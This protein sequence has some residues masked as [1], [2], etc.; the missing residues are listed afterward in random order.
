M[1]KALLFWAFLL[2]ASSPSQAAAPY[3]PG[4][5]VVRLRQAPAAM[6]IPLSASQFG[7]LGAPLETM[8]GRHSVLSLKGLSSRL[9]Q[10]RLLE[11]SSA[12]DIPALAGRLGREALV[13]LAE[14]D[15]YAQPL[16]APN[17]PLFAQQWHH[18]NTGQTG[19]TAGADVGSTAAW[20]VWTGSA[21]VV[22]AVLDTGIELSHPDLSANIASGGW[23]FIDNDAT[24]EDANGHGTH[25]SGII[26]AQGNNFSAVSG[27]LWRAK[28]L[29]LK[30]CGSGGC[31]FTAIADALHFAANNG[32]RVINMSLG[33]PSGSSLLEEAVNDA[34]A[35]G[36]VVVAAA[37]N[38]GTESPSY[39]A[40]Y[41]NVIAV[42]A[43]DHRD[44]LASFSQRGSWVDISAPG[45][46]ILSTY[47]GGSTALL[48]GTSMA[49]PM[50]AGAAGLIFSLQ[51]SLTAA[52]VRLRLT[53]SAA[54]IDAQNPG[55]SGK[56]GAG[57]LQ[58]GA[59]MALAPQILS[60]SIAPDEAFLNNA[61]LANYQAQL[62]TGILGGRAV[63]LDQLD[64]ELGLGNTAQFVV[65]G[66]SLVSGSIQIGNLAGRYPL[67]SSVHL[68][69][70]FNHGSY[71]SSQT[72]KTWQFRETASLP[73]GGRAAVWNAVFDPTQGGKATVRLTLEQAGRVTVR[74][75]R[76][77]GTPIRTLVD[78]EA[79][80]GVRTWDWAGTNTMGSVAASGLY[81]IHIR[82][83]GV[84][85]VKK[86]VLVK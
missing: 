26:A 76:P 72:V 86:T 18:R 4:R 62:S 21:N 31:P 16:A 41:S 70:E 57:R 36:C 22:I 5:V 45:D 10:W 3:V 42:S 75:L 23:D 7:Q 73:P 38:S 43:T 84:N 67:V 59:A 74:V 83:P 19:G 39:P 37:G 50:V 8:L 29:A 27:I 58:V 2:C 85:V 40:F 61:L 49:S 68:R 82:G 64:R 25:V 32:A 1:K 71:V 55:L 14:P 46:N 30:V 77:D 52:E 66:S 69:L 60:F 33:G 17:D 54:N 51:P 79:A 44:V 20:D 13:E 65:T 15:Y 78:E 80:A 56:L 48:S 9:P 28:I 35:A 24:P 34:S 11:V 63:L 81:L 53:S 47:L 6:A 12:T